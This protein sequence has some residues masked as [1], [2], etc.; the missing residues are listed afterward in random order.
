[1][2]ERLHPRDRRVE[3]TAKLRRVGVEP[4]H[5]FG[6]DLAFDLELLDVVQ[7]RTLFGGEAIGLV[8][9]RLQPF[10]RAPR[11]RFGAGAV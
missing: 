3:L 4:L 6:A 10:G 9:Q 11:Q 1:L 5:L 8:L 2:L 7:Q